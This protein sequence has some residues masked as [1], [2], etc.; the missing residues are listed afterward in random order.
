MAKKHGVGKWM[1]GK[2]M[3][4]E[5]SKKKSEKLKGELNPNWQGGVSF[6]P[7]GLEFNKELKEKIRKRDGH[8]CQECK[9]P[10][11]GLNYKLH[12]H[13]IDYNKKNSDE[14]N[15]ISL[16]RSCHL[17]TNYSRKDWTNYFIGKVYR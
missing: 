1:K 5:S 12:V 11:E 3:S 4:E 17:Q 7:Y 2:K 6:E 13:H 14:E 9:Y 16:C 8:V 15:L 10:Q